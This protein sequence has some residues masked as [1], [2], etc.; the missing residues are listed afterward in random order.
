MTHIT[1]P[2]TCNHFFSLLFDVPSSVPDPI[3]AL[4]ANQSNPIL[5]LPPYALLRLLSSP[6]TTPYICIVRTDTPTQLQNPS[7][8]STQL[9]NTL[10]AKFPQAFPTELPQDPPPPDRVPTCHRLT[11]QLYYSPPPLISPNTRGTTRNKAP[12]D[13]YLNSQQIA[14]LPAHLVPPYYS[15]ARKMDLCVCALIIMD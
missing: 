12:N 10:L 7:D 15:C 9:R 1:I 14:P 2:F 6:A 8:P 5:L 4:V 3:L 11:T 13:E